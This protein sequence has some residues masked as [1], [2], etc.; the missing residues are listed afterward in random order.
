MKKIG[1]NMWWA[2]QL[3]SIISSNNKRIITILNTK[4]DTLKDEKIARNKEG[5]L[6]STI[7]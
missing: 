2:N 7:V 5:I 4:V 6:T 1:E 3:S